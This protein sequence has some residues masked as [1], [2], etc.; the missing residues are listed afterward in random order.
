MNNSAVLPEPPC[1]HQQCEAFRISKGPGPH[2]LHP[3]NQKIGDKVGFNPA[4]G[5]WSAKSN[6][7]LPYLR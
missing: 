2:G 1:L 6:G 5:I 4:E 3:E 7:L